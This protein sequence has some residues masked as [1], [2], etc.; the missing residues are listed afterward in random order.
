MISDWR[1]RAEALGWPRKDLDGLALILS[2]P[3][4]STDEVVAVTANR[5]A[6]RRRCTMRI[7][8]TSTNGQTFFDHHADGIWYWRNHPPPQSRSAETI[9]DDSPWCYSHGLECDPESNGRCGYSLR[10]EGVC[11]RLQCNCRRMPHAPGCELIEA[12]GGLPPSDE[13]SRLERAR[14][15]VHARIDRQAS[16]SASPAN[17]EPPPEKIERPSKKNDWFIP[18]QTKLPMVAPPTTTK[19]EE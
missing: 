14:A 11:R 7:F 9:K 18:G 10:A 5:I 8:G 2:T 15:A 4:T 13:K 17:W 19:G 6:I 1:A 12:L 3:S 16:I